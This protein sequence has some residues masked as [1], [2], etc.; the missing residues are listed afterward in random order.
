M[1]HNPQK[2]LRL[3]SEIRSKFLDLKL[4]EAQNRHSITVIH[5][6]IWPLKN[7]KF[8]VLS[9]LKTL[10]KMR[11]PLSQVDELLVSF[12]QARSN[13]L[14]LRQTSIRSAK[15]HLSSA[16]WT[17]TNC[18]PKRPWPRCPKKHYNRRL[19]WKDHSFRRPQPTTKSV[20]MELVQ[21]Q[22]Q[23]KTVAEIGWL[24]IQ[25]LL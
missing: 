6:K 2:L 22:R 14:K 10:S 1:L 19:V 24:Q 21:S 7:T 15:K 23:R 13:R 11:R 3:N 20:I 16:W 12:H 25:M 18:K 5:R 8:R 4:L 9:K 17:L